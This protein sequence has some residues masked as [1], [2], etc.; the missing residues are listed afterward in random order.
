MG[1][2]KTEFDPLELKK[3]YS[4]EGSELRF[5]QMQLLEIMKYVIKVCEQNHLTCWLSGGT[6]LGACLY[7]GFIP[8]DDDIDLDMPW[9]DYKKFRK[10]VKKEGKYSFQD[11]TTDIFYPYYFGKVR[12]ERIYKKDETMALQFSSY[13]GIF[14]DIIP[15]ERCFKPL[16]DISYK[17]LCGGFFKSMALAHRHPIFK[18][19]LFARRF[20]NDIIIS[21]FRLISRFGN[22]LF[23]DTYSVGDSRVHKIKN[24]NDFQTIKFEGLECKAPSDVETYL[25]TW[26]HWADYHKLPDLSNVSKYQHYKW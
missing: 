9:K 12:D 10:I 17:L 20:I 26:Y 24:M 2:V 4:P 18:S 7:D 1:I 14:I 5:F 8:W 23:Y 6:L 13:S 11:K 25:K 16:K 15:V 3:K 22:N 21:L 19:F